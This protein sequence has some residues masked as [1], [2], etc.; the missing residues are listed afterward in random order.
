MPA[1]VYLAADFVTR[2][3]ALLPRGRAWP[4]DPDAVQ[5]AVL[6]GLALSYARSTAAANGLLVDGFPATTV[7]LLPEWQQTLGLPDP[8]AVP[9]PTLQ[10]QQDQVLARFVSVGG[11]S[12]QAYIDYAATLGYSINIRNHATFRMGVSKMG[13]S[14]GSPQW[15]FVWE[16][17]CAALDA[18]LQCELNALNQAHTPLLFSTT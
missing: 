7:N 9:S 12:T 10:Q 5:T 1:P 8:C 6:A 16:V 3:Q 18:V 4:R 14:L 17:V 2:L 11:N 13:D 15:I